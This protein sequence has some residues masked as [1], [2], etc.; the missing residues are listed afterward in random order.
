M[1]EMVINAK[2]DF[3]MVGVLI[4]GWQKVC[5]R[6]VDTVAFANFLCCLVALLQVL[7]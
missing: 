3:C 2:S 6:L 5:G 1:Q 7:I 4:E